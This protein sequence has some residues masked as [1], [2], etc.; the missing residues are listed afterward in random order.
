MSQGVQITGAVLILGAFALAQVR[1]LP[2][3]SYRYLLLNLVGAGLLAGDAFVERQW[4]FFAL[5]S[6]WAAV[7]TVSLAVRLR[8]AAGPRDV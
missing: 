2:H 8:G 1:L 5:N 7:S 6:V 4:G 3:A